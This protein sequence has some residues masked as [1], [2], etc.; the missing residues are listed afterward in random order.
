MTQ[1][2]PRSIA[3]FARCA[4]LLS[5]SVA[6]G[7]LLPHAP[8]RA[9]ERDKIQAFLQVTGFD[10]A[11][12][13]IALSAGN[14]PQM[15][16]LEA[17]DFGS[18]WTRLADEVFDVRQMNEIALDILEATLDDEMLTH[19]AGFYATDLG[20]RLV[21]VENDSHMMADEDRKQELGTQ[22][23]AELVES[24]SPR[25]ALLKRMGTAIDATGQGLRALQQI[26]IR[27]LMAASAAGVVELRMDEDEL[28]ALMKTQEG[29][30]LRA[31]Q[32]SSLTG[33]AY[34]YAPFTDAEV[35]TYVEALENPLMRKVYEL[36]NAV[37]YEITANRFEILASRMAELHPGQDI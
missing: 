4:L 31:L 20:Q 3:P 29:E 5:L 37:Q 23:V 6:L 10:V 2:A 24:G 16:G 19:A 33:A 7:L 28:R 8:A 12:D 11:L 1:I 15:L 27:F 26:Q 14:A 21:E 32:L 18:D 9:A 36:L 22:I 35:E 17:D 34:T 25:L 30:L 13:S